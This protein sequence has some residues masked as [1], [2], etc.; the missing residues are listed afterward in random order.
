MAM[1]E[2]EKRGVVRKLDVPEKDLG[3]PS[4]TPPRS[5]NFK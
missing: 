1:K 2:L 5:P 4:M 3:A